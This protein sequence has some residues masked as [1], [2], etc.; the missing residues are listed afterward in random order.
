[1]KTFVFINRVYPPV[2][3]ATGEL[4]KELAEVLADTDARVVVVTSRGPSELDLPDR[5]TVNCV[6]VVRVGSAPFSRGSHWRRGLSY[7]SLYPALMW[8]IWKLGRVDVVVSMTDPPLLVA[9]VT[10][11]SYGAKKRVHWAQD[12]YPELAEEL[13][14]IRHRGLLARVLRSISTWAL[15]KQDEIVVLGRCMRERL[16]GR[17]IDASKIEIIPNWT[18]LVKPSADKV[19][20]M[21]AKLGWNSEFI[22][23]YSG[24]IGL[25]HDFATLVEAAKTLEGSKVRLVFAGEGP[26][27]AELQRGCA[28]L[29][30]V[31]F[32]PS[33][34]KEHLSEFL[35]AADV[36]LVSV[37]EGLE[38]LV[39]PS[40]AYGVFALEKLM[41][42]VGSHNSEVAR[43]I[44]ETHAGTVVSNG[45]AHGLANAL[46]RYAEKQ[47]E[48]EGRHVVTD[49]SLPTALVRWRDI[50]NHK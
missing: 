37:W 9:A 49:V 48:N 15:R 27:L 7:L 36:H 3:G 19:A 50:L 17:G 29:P 11:A 41:I 31:S 32:L 24:N 5:E 43:L 20:A 35:A 25:A 26:S 38:G 10:F 18:S 13:G 6:E 45:D 28:G 46:H 22:A 8:Q 1:M 12:V 42:Y 16:I 34:P 21:R 23:L 4:L 40:K 33:Q 14:V 39:V 30:H 2:R 44:Q 47:A